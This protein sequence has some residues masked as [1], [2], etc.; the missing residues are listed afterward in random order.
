MDLLFFGERKSE[1]NE[2]SGIEL[3]NQYSLA[4]IAMNIHLLIE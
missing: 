4:V 2:Y 3:T 1:Q